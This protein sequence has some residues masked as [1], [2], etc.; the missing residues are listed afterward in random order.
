VK[1]RNNVLLR[2]AYDLLKK[3]RDS[4]YVLSAMSATVFYDDAECDGLCLLED[5]A[6]ELDIVEDSRNYGAK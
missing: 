4:H 3:C 1:D 6:D 5:I 2:A